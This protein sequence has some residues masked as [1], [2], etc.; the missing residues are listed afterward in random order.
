MLPFHRH[1][2]GEIHKSSTLD[3]PGDHLGGLVSQQPQVRELHTARASLGALSSSQTAV[4][5]AVAACKAAESTGVQRVQ[6]DSWFGRTA[7]K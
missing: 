4:P 2:A 5:A 1:G 3:H 7:A 6:G